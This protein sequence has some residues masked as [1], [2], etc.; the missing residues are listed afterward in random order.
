MVQVLLFSAFLFSFRSLQFHIQLISKRTDSEIR[1]VAREVLRPSKHWKLG[2]SLVPFRGSTSFLCHGE[3]IIV[4]TEVNLWPRERGWVG[5]LSSGGA[6][7]KG[8]ILV[9]SKTF[10]RLP[11]VRCHVY[12]KN[13]AKPN[14]TSHNTFNSHAPDTTALRSN[15]FLSGICRLLVTNN[16][17]SNHWEITVKVKVVL[18][19]RRQPRGLNLVSGALEF[20]PNQKAYVIRG[21]Q[22]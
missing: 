6:W 22:G 9:L 13:K 20:V 21:G 17:R 16:E 15:A 5:P 2:F 8:G 3:N 19:S 7:G 1:Q 10:H 11:F 18:S 12:N 4:Y 14:S